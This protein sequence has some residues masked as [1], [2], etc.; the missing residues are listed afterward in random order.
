M[1]SESVALPDPSRAGLDTSVVLRLLVGEPVDQADRALSYLASHQ[2]KGRICFVND[3]VVT[4]AYYALCSYY[5]VPKRE[6]LKLLFEFLTSG[7]VQASGKA[8]QVLQQ[9]LVASAK[10]GFVDRLIH[11]Q[12]QADGAGL[13]TFEKAAGRLTGALVLTG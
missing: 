2:A 1:T 3:V 7:E 11:T 10:P 8:L 4:E 9:T 13:V 6:A 12:Y 5:A